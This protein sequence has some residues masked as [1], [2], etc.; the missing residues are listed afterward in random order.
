MSVH[1]QGLCKYVFE[2]YL[3]VVHVHM[4]ECTHA[5]THVLLEDNF[6]EQ[7]L[8]LSFHPVSP[9]DTTQVP[10]LSDKCCYPLSHLS[11]SCECKLSFLWN[12]NP[13]C[14]VI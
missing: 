9:G 3:F 12:N 6:K 14:W 5:T 10:R 11:G 4:C 8:V 13:N 2:I 7:E 1:V